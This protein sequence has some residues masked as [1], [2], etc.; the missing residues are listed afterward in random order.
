MNRFYF[1]DGQ[2]E[3]GPFTVNELKAQ[4]LTRTTPIR[5]KDS[6]KWMP[7]EKLA[8][9]KPLLVPRKIKAVRDVLPAVSEN[10]VVLHRERPKTL[11]GV[12]FC[13]AM[14]AGLSF[15]SLA[16]PIQKPVALK[17][18]V[19]NISAPAAGDVKTNP[20]EKSN[21]TTPV[22]KEPKKDNAVVPTKTQWN[23]LVTATNSN[24]GIGFLGG[25]KDLS[26]I[27]TNRTDFPLDEVVTKVTYIKAG[28]GIWKTVPVT[29]YGILP[30]ETKEQ[31][32]PDVNRG[33]KVK[34]SLQKVVSKKM[35][36]NY[37][38]G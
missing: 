36:V 35:S 24:Y 16:K 12:L 18:S 15:Y 29:I 28:G 1:Y 6:D 5:Q 38:A 4:K 2:N 19:A 25:I 23:K 31:T 21:A 11:Y 30:H 37:T 22:E 8:D 9:L 27:V 7:A 3:V 13:L 14:L 17:P 32:V 20:A 26:V 34:V 33:K 10:L